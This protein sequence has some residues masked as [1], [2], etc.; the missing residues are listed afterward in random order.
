MKTYLYAISRYQW[1]KTLRKNK[2][3]E[4]F[5][6][7]FDLPDMSS[8]IVRIMEKAEIFRILQKL[9]AKFN[10]NNRKIL[11]MYFQKYSTEEIAL[12]LNLSKQYVKKKKYECKKQL[13]EYIKID[14][15][16]KEL[17]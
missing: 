16:L 6:E 12:K 8:D 9:L 13:I 1:L 14:N 7:G 17:I 15:R 3:E 4:R 11:E 5:I 10:P 2:K